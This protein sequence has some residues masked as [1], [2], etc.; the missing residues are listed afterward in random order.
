MKARKLIQSNSCENN[1]KWLL[2]FSKVYLPS[3]LE[4]AGRVINLLNH[5]NLY[6]DE[7]WTRVGKQG[8]P[9][10]LSASPNPTLNH[11]PSLGFCKSSNFYRLF[12]VAHR[13]PQTSLLHTLYTQ[14]VTISDLALIMHVVM[15]DRLFIQ[16]VTKRPLFTADQRF[17]VPRWG[18]WN[19]ELLVK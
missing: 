8:R 5:F 17:F 18:M 10:P 14:V 9:H 3:N 2:L 16:Q 15:S 1:G 11:S 12:L 19:I 6:S 4:V 13:S 7:K